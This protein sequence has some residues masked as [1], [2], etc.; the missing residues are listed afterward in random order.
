MEHRL[1]AG[2]RVKTERTGG[3]AQ[4]TNQVISKDASCSLPCLPRPLLHE[5]TDLCPFFELGLVLRLLPKGNTSHRVKPS[6]LHPGLSSPCVRIQREQKHS[7]GQRLRSQARPNSSCQPSK[8]PSCTSLS[9]E[10]PAA[11]ITNKISTTARPGRTHLQ[12]LH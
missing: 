10:G 7:S 9:F 3:R 12:S 2:T 1:L 5:G 8:Q 11:Y 4:V 6:S